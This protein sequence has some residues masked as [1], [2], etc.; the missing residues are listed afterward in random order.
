[1]TDKERI[2]R[3]EQMV[4][5]L[6]ETLMSVVSVV[7]TGSYEYNLRDVRDVL[8]GENKGEF[9]QEVKGEGE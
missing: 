8:Q 1:M 9:K 5:T 4:L 3:L 7:N 2:L 6:A